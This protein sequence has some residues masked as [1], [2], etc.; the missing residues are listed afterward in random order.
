M[1]C[2]VC[3]RESFEVAV[4]LGMQPLAHHFLS[5][6]QVG[7][8]LFYPLRLLWCKCCKTAQL[9]HT[10]KKEIVY[11]DHTYLAGITKSL[12]EHFGR[13][14]KEIDERFFKN[15]KSKSI[16]DIGSNDGTQLKAFQALG[17][18]V[19]GVEAAKTIA[20]I[21]NRDHVPTIHAFYNLETADRIGKYFD[22][23][24]ASGVFFHLEE[25][26]SVTEAI[27]KY[28]KPN[29]VFVVQCMYMK[30]IIEHC[31]FDQIY[32]EH[33][34]FYTLETLEKLLNLHGLALF[35]VQFSPIH[36][37]S[38]IA[39]VGHQGRRTPSARL[40][41]MREEETHSGCNEISAYRAFAKGVE[42]MK[43]ENLAFLEKKKKEGKRVFGMGAP[44]KGNTLLNYCG[45]GKNYLECLVEKNELRRG[46]Y[47]PGM[48]LPIRIEKEVMPP[49][50]YYVLAWNFKDEILKNN[51]ALIERGV[52]FYFPVNP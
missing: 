1:K 36:G 47:S 20:E 28:L 17:Y 45:I 49:D 52:E 29:G 48:H 46:L 6:E 8:E 33:L 23:F 24:N 21:A 39:F 2:R 15:Q 42:K 16:F 34:L 12:A 40:E 4:D 11:T 38:L 3:D 7:K 50:I 41:K 26:H 25:L 51:Q 9:D 13:I 19:L 43:Q 44:V 18:D 10:V 35:D 37:G 5:Q 31:A 32:H 30:S 22:I 14:A 27:R